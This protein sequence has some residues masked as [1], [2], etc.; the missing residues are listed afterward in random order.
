MNTRE[1]SRWKRWGKGGAAVLAGALALGAGW[2][3]LASA[4]EAAQLERSG[5]MVDV[6]THRMHL[7]CTGRGSPT[8]VLESGATGGS[9]PWAWVQAEL[10]QQTRVCSYD[11]S[12]M[13]WS[14]ASPLPRTAA[15]V[16]AE[17]RTLLANAGEEG[18]FVLVGHS[19]GGIYARRFVADHPEDVAGLVLLDSSHPDQ[20]DRLGDEARKLQSAFTSILQASP[21]LAHV[22]LMRATDLF[23]AQA[24][25]LPPAALAAAAH[26]VTQPGHLRTSAAELAHWDES[27]A[28]VR[29]AGPFGDLPLSVISAEKGDDAWLQLHREMASLSSR[30]HYRVIPEADHLSVVMRKD[31][32]AAV[33]A[34]IGELLAVV[35]NGGEA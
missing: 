22:G 9:S 13:Q 1:Q 15:N 32:A 17:L 10:A 24:E 4:H 27:M 35:R 3:A 14:E 30:A 28:Q 33:A 23:A 6:G 7:H 19:L 2:Q 18:P 31:H 25:G 29:G 21:W 26:F 16:S 20:L 8:V 12:G 34:A 11:R 5:R